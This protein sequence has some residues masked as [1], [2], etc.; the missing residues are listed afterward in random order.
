MIAD[1]NHSDDFG[2]G[3]PMAGL[4]A[5]GDLRNLMLSTGIWKQL[6]RLE[7]VK[8]VRTSSEHDPENYGSVT[9]QAITLAEISAA[10]RARV[11]CMAITTPGPN[12]EGNPSAW[13]SAI[14]MA[15][16]GVEEGGAGIPRII[17]I[18][19]GNIREHPSDFSYPSA[20]NEAPTQI[21]FHAC[22]GSSMGAS[23]TAEG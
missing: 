9:L 5:F 8:L 6:H 21:A 16:A 2:H 11:F 22:A 12:T 18:S 19:A 3:T 1:G 20:V 15:A 13:S 7:S 10:Q 17:L 14:D 23:F 4:A